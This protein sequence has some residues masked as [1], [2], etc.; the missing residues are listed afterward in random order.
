[1]ALPRFI[2][3]LFSPRPPRPD[4]FVTMCVAFRQRLAAWPVKHRPTPDAQRVGVLVTPWLSTAAPLFSL[5]CG[6]ML[7]RAGCAATALSDFS[8]VIGNAEKLTHNE[9]LAGVLAALPAGFAL[10]QI[11]SGGEETCT[12]ED[13]ALAT[14]LLHENAIWKMR[15]EQRAG[16][17]SAEQPHAEAA[18]A[19]HIAVVRRTL[20]SS[21]L[22]WV[23]VPGGIYGLSG[24]YLAILKE[25]GIGF[26]TYDSGK[27]LLRFS[28]DCVTTHLEDMPLVCRLVAERERNSPAARERLIARATSELA[29]RANAKDDLGYQLAAASGEAV[30][31]YDILVPLN[32]RWDAAAL[33]RQKL[34][35]SVDAWLIAVLE[36]VAGHPTASICIRQHPIERRE[37]LKSTD[38]YAP[39][40]ERFRHLGDR[41]R[42][43]AAEEEISTYDILHHARVVLPHTSTVGIEAAMLGKPVLLSTHCYYE[44]LGFVWVPDS[45]EEYFRLIAAAL[46]GS[47]TLNEQQRSDAA[48]AFYL[49]QR[50]ALLRTGFTPDPEDFLQWVQH[51]P[52]ELWAQDENADVSTA[53]ISRQPLP[54][55]RY[56]RL[57]HAD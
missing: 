6:L 19:R 52:E 57:A 12:P 44:S 47:L 8:D 43:V 39:I 37:N 17:F 2:T 29:T 49:T 41:F 55:V 50:C 31:H 42:F 27:G 54:F 9:A 38:N 16:D 28:H 11:T 51:T 34:F 40:I 33:S 36:W 15:G 35:A 1:M 26:T 5:E 46:A 45:S 20:R 4:A 10:L 3:S 53:L 14:R 18:L 24:I 25:L 22:S 23:L 30:R 7:L 21:G 48:I 56:Q 32:I 13:R